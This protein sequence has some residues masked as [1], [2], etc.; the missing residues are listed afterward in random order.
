LAGFLA[1]VEPA[2]AVPTLRALHR[3]DQGLELA[4][5]LLGQVMRGGF[6]Q[7]LTAKALEMLDVLLERGH[8]AAFHAG[9]TGER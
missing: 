2:P 1:S 5:F 3:L 6:E 4:K 8:H 9:V 7:A